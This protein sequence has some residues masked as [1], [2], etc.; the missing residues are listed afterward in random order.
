MILIGKLEDLNAHFGI[1]CLSLGLLGI[2]IPLDRNLRGGQEHPTLIQ[3]SRREDLIKK[4]DSMDLGSHARNGMPW[5]KNALI[6]G[7]SSSGLTAC[8][9]ST[10][11]K[12]TNFTSII[13]VERLTGHSSQ[14]DL[15]PNSWNDL[16]RNHETING[17]SLPRAFFTDFGKVAE[18]EA[19][20]F[21]L[22]GKL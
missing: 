4:L 6:W 16:D 15:S 13:Q 14:Y 22:S 1:S 19:K 5:K 3:P 18:D 12:R 8:V 7:E 11:S 2:E 20:H 17:K 9:L 21:T 10:Q